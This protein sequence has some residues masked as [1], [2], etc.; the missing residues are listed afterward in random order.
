MMMHEKPSNLCC[1]PRRP[2]ILI[3]DWNGDT[4]GY[5]VPG[6]PFLLQVLS[7]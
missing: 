7:T 6:D 2:P 3:S 5:L 4:F 1:G